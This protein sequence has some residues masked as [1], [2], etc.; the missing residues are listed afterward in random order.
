[1]FEIDPE[2]RE[3]IIMWLFRVGF[4]LLVVLAL[5]LLLRG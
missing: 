4:A 2:T 1:V 3:R 5:V